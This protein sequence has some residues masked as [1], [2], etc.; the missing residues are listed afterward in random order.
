MFFH[1]Y[2]N[3]KMKLGFRLRGLAR[4]QGSKAVVEKKETSQWLHRNRF[5]QK[6]N[7]IRTQI[8]YNNCKA[9][10]QRVQCVYYK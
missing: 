8:D 7:V 5:I 9:I 10:I 2:I 6:E 3:H 1:M 4:G